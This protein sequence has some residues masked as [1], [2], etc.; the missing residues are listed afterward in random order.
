MKTTA[1]CVEV[2]QADELVD[3]ARRARAAEDDDVVLAPVDGPVDGAAGVLPQRRG[4]APGRRRLRV[5]VGVQRQDAVAD[6][7]LDER[8]RAAGGGGVR[9]HEAAR[10]E[11]PVEHRA[12][13]DH[14]VGG[15]ARSGATRCGPDH[16]AGALREPGAVGGE[17]GGTS[18]PAVPARSA[19]AARA[20]RRSGAPPPWTRVRARG[21]D[22]EERVSWATDAMSGGARFATWSHRRF[23][24]LTLK[25]ADG[26]PEIAEPTLLEREAELAQIDAALRAAC[27][28]SRCG[29]RDRGRARDRQEL[30]DGTRPASWPRRAGW[31][32][33]VRGA[34]V[35]ERS[36]R[37]A[38]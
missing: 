25:A 23:S 13:A 33:C 9:V 36:S 8:Q 4:L 31:L 15:S 10:A 20:G 19:W 5:R 14:R 21:E 35:M 24:T 16:L 34:G 6:E 2:E 1:R 3:R 29:H 30:V 38:W 12:V 32:C 37:S 18:R 11:R 27:R 17:T 28:R 22:G 26:G 7:V